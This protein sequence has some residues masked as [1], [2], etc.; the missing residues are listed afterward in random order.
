MF[1]DELRKDYNGLIDNQKFEEYFR[2]SLMEFTIE[3]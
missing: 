3:K 2:N 1:H